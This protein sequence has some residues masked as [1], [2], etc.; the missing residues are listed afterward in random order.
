MLW[1]ILLLIL[2]PA[3]AETLTCEQVAPMMFTMRLAHYGGE[4]VGEAALERVV[5]VYAEALDPGRVLLLEEDVDR[6]RGSLLLDLLTDRPDC[7]ALSALDERVK[8]RAR[9]DAS[10]ARTFLG[11]GYALDE[12]ATLEA[13]ADARGFARTEAERVARVKTML[14]FQVAVHLRAKRPLE[15]ATRRVRE[16]YARTAERLSSRSE[17]APERFVK[18]FALSLDPHTAYLSHDDLVDFEISMNLSL[19]GIGAVLRWDDGYTIVRSVVAGG[20][21]DKEG[22]LAPGDRIL[23][24]AQGEEE[25]VDV[26]GTDLTDVVKLIRGE[27]GTTVVLTIARGQGAPFDLR[28]LREKI[29]VGE[30]AAN[31]RMVEREVDGE[32]LKVGVIELS[33]FYG[34]EQ[35]R[36]ASDDVHAL[37]DQAHEEG[38]DAMV[39][40]LSSNGG[41]LLQEAVEVTG[42]FLAEGPVVATE[43]PSNLV[44]LSDEDATTVWT[45]PLVVLVSEMS[46]SASEIAAGTLQGY[47]RAVVVGGESTFGKGSV[48]LMS[49]LPGDLGALKLTTAMYF[50]PSG[51]SVQGT[52]VRSQVLL[53]S[54]LAGLDL[55]EADLPYALPPVSREPFPS[56]RVRDPSHPWQVVSEARVK[57]LAERSRARVGED[58][59]LQEVLAWTREAQGDGPAVLGEVM[60]EAEQDEDA[61]DFDVWHDA[62]VGESASIAADLAAL[63]E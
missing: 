9:A 38:A 55:R 44:I 51:Q 27:K 33:A 12:T 48:Q 11:E 20:A 49:G 45:G 16:Q 25:P 22:T 8:T 15:E 3:R 46:A 34:S 28:L 5:D 32:T 40:D 17:Q 31:L 26:V 6:L 29:D 47:G 61:L 10:L 2:S 7:S 53:P 58:E 41:G 35:G 24:V 4:E 13:D 50:L 63:S 1:S 52:G 23:A 21:A 59:S 60:T 14:H 57:A 39:L 62:F 30:Q 37:L 36:T 18:A 19:E 56:E 43:S 42:L 54:V